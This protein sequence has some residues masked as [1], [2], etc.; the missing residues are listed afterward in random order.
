[1]LRGAFYALEHAW[2]LLRDAAVLDQAGS[3]G[4]ALALAALS[5]E[6]VGLSR[7]FLDAATRAFH[8]PSGRV[9]FSFKGRAVDHVAKLRAG[10]SPWT[11]TVNTS[12]F[13]TSDED[14]GIRLD[15]LRKLREEQ[16]PR[17][18]YKKKNRALYVE[19]AAGGYRWNRP[20]D[21]RK[22]Q[23]GEMRS[24]AALDYG[25]AR[26]LL[27]EP[28]DSRMRE[29]IEAAKHLLPMLPE[30]PWANDK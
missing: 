24:A 3:H 27:L 25:H 28:K 5:R 8:H 15:R 12:V 22:D 13:G 21:V 9:P 17:E 29:A 2:E 4:H 20:C 7:I 23:T 26:R 19:P 6:E 16:L 30:T 18:A 1:M 14:L 11:V 10:Q